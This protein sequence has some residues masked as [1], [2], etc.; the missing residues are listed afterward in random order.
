MTGEGL[1]SFQRYTNASLSVM[2]ESESSPFSL[3]TLN[4]ASASFQRVIRNS[5]QVADRET[6]N[7]LSSI[8]N[9]ADGLLAQTTEGEASRTRSSFSFRNSKSTQES[10]F[11]K[12]GIPEKSISPR[13]IPELLRERRIDDLFLVLLLPHG[14][15]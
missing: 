7:S 4:G 10:P 1:Y 14:D 6:L 12:K 15:H 2:L 11:S 5:F 3:T 9:G 13:S 8:F